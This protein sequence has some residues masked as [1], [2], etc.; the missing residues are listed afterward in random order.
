MQACQGNKKKQGEDDNEKYK[1]DKKIERKGEC[2]K[3]VGNLSTNLY[4]KLYN[5]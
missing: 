5:K 1:E 4:L 2:L 3:F